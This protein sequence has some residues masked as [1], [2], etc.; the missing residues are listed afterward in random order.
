MITG[1]CWAFKQNTQATLILKMTHHDIESYRILIL[2]LLSRLAPF[3]CRVLIIHGFLD[4]T[5]YRQ[6]MDMTCFYVNT[7]TCEGL[8]LPL[9]EFLSAG[10]PAI[11]PSHTA[12]R[13]YMAEDFAWILN[14]SPQPASWPHD[15]TAMLATRLHRLNWDSLVRA[16]QDSYQVATGEPETYA[17]LSLN[18]EKALGHY[19]SIQRVGEQ[20]QNFLNP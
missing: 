3:Q 1:F 13:D 12:M 6:L 14:S 4:D 19:A 11:A 9:M 17:T 10:K 5:Q 15:P 16:Y 7:S 2:T 8:C 20:L 18:A